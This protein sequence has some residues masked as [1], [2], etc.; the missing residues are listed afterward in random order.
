MSR[1]TINWVK[2]VI[3]AMFGALA[4]ILA[5]PASADTDTDFNNELHL[6]GLYAP[7]DYNAWIG[8][9][10]CKR[11]STGLDADAGEAA[12]F[13]KRNL[14]R[15]ADEQQVYQFLGGAIR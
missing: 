1:H 10:V 3:L 7:K 15:D 11:L 14:D 4:L 6:Y 8:K 5:A 13:L 9:I 2:T 12:T